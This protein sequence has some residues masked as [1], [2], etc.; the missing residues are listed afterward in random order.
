METKIKNRNN[1]IVQYSLERKK[2]KNINLRID[3]TGKIFVSAGKNVPTFVIDDFI[4]R[5]FDWIEK[6][7]QTIMKNEKIRSDSQ[8][9]NGKKVFFFGKEFVVDF[10]KSKNFSI[11]MEGNRLVILSKW[12]ENSEDLH[13]AYLFWLKN[14]SKPLFNQ[15]LKEE[16]EKVKKYGVVFPSFTI[17]NMKTRWGSCMIHKNK[18]CL[19]L[20]LA[21]AKPECIKQV[22]LH[23][24][25]HFIYPNHSK[26][27]YCLLTELMPDWKQRREMLENNFQDGM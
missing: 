16:F 20:Q 11:I 5:K 12:E 7:L 13:N 19:N 6:K 15:F 26:D 2:V 8:I 4:N 18:I 3:R 23:E 17:R 9:Y 24:L 27:F 25:V 21:K 14:K 10:E 1:K 22:I